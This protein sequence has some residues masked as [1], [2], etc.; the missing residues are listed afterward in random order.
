MHRLLFFRAVI[1]RSTRATFF[2]YLLC[3]VFCLIC[4]VRLVISVRE[5]LFF[6]VSF[7]FLC[8]PTATLLFS[9]LDAFKDFF[10]ARLEAKEELLLLADD[11]SGLEE[12][13]SEGIKLR[14]LLRE[15]ELIG[16]TCN[17]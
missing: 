6:L 15:D 7:S 11:G 1:S 14:L 16:C 4:V 8:L 13:E 12:E 5:G 10:F 3:P 2:S 17:G 9:L